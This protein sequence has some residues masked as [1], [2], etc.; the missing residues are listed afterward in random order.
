MYS[1]YSWITFS[2]LRV[3]IINVS[4]Y[5][6]AMGFPGGSVVKNPPAN[7][8]DM[9]SISGWGRS[10]GGGDSN[11]LQCSCLGNPMHKAAQQAA[12]Q[13]VAKSQTGLSD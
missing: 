13:G 10:S 12:V 2:F 5:P 1:E 4:Y 6:G 3:V 7:A 9:D 8:E 11:P